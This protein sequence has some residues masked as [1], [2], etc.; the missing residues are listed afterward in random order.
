[1]NLLQ[2]G[3]NVSGLLYFVRDCDR[4]ETIDIQRG[5][6]T[7]KIDEKLVEEAC[8]VGNHHSGEEAI[9]AALEHYIRVRK[10]PAILEHFGTV[11][12]D[13]AYDYKAARRRKAD[14][15]LD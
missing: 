14:R 12:F 7:F 13:P 3:E 8:R 10:Q 11:Y 2:A 4:H 15:N 9:L 1:L 6:T 5:V